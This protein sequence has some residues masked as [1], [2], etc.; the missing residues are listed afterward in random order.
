[1]RFEEGEA[2]AVCGPESG[3]APP[4]WAV[5]PGLAAIILVALLLRTWQL[6]NESPWW[7]EIVTLKILDAPSVVE[8]VQLERAADPPMTPGYFALAYYWSRLAGTSTIAMRWLSVLLGLLALP[9]TYVLARRLYNP[10]AAL[11]AAAAHAAALPHVYY[12][13]EV[14]VYALV[15]LLTLVSTYAF[16]RTLQDQRPAWWTVHLAAN[17]LLTFTHLFTVLLF[18]AQGCFLLVLRWRQPKLVAAWSAA[19][20]AFLA[21][22]GLWLSTVDLSSV[23]EAASWMVAPGLREFAMTFLI[24]AGG[25]PHN[26][27]PA[28]H[29]PSGMTLDWA[30]TLLF[31]G[32]I[33]WFVVKTLLQRRDEDRESGGASSAPE[34]LG[35]LL[36]WL[37]IPIGLLF[38]ASLTWRPCFVYR[39]IL[40]S[41]LPLYI[42]LGGAVSSIRATRAKALIIGTLVI[43]FAHQAAGIALGPFR[44]DWQRLSRHLET[45]IHPDDTV[46]AFQEIGLNALN[47]NS[48]LPETQLQL[49]RVWSEVCPAVLEAHA[50][51]GD[52]WIT[53]WLWSDPAN[54]EACFPANDL[55]ATHVDFPGWPNL[56]LYHVPRPD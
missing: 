49:A 52:A 15:T 33:G 40:F 23:H 44:P 50:R 54:I 46:V 20:G 7:D 5:L 28:A 48:N 1:M 31:A 37:A 9:L 56:R 43:L 41:S 14:R 34:A 4:T 30:L 11:I 6:T 12:S 17:F 26:E 53:V 55:D 36:C 32:V 19:H 10:T 13:Q 25:R 35:L 18:V 38:I 3:T 39:Y 8:F 29:L 24:F 42:L 21:L 47:F 51:G 45:H 16:W 22:L 27:N 2:P